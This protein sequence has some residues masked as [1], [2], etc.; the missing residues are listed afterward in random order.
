MIEIP[1]ISRFNTG[2]NKVRLVGGWVRDFTVN[3]TSKDI[4]L[5]VEAPMDTTMDEFVEWASQFGFF[6]GKV[7]DKFTAKVKIPDLSENP[8][9]FV[10][11]RKEVDGK[12]WERGTFHDDMIRR[13]FTCN[14][15]A[16]ES[17]GSIIDLFGG[18]KDMSDGIL[19]CVGDAFKRFDED[20]DRFG[21]AFRF[22]SVNNWKLDDPILD[23]MNDDRLMESFATSNTDRK[24]EE[25]NKALKDDPVGA[26]R[27][28]AALPVKFQEAFLSNDGR[29]SHFQLHFKGPPN[30]KGKKQNEILD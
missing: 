18:R 16:I 4:D 17:D 28:F 6:V 13:D 26:M 30:E 15:M 21:R 29:P 22:A 1:D 25:F 19:R 5:A 24:G 27:L 7:E 9:D 20:A 3:K 23:A 11:C 14:A 8:I 2:P 10:L 12:G